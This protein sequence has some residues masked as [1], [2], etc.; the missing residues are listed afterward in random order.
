MQIHVCLLKSTSF[1]DLNTEHMQFRQ[2]AAK[3]KTFITVYIVQ[4]N[5]R[6]T[7]NLQKITHFSGYDC[8]KSIN[9]V[10]I[11]KCDVDCVYRI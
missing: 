5:V 4:P 10:C 2:I 7:R 8:F 3:V 9:I 6:W 1:S 11:L